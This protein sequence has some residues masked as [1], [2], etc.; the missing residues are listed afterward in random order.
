MKQKTNFNSNLKS[1]KE[2]SKKVVRP[3]SVFKKEVGPIK[4]L[5]KNQEKINDNNSIENKKENDE[6][7]D[8]NLL[9]ESKL[10]KN[11]TESNFNNFNSLNSNDEIIPEN[12]IDNQLPLL[13]IN[14]HTLPNNRAKTAKDRYKLKL[15][16]LETMFNIKP[17][18]YY[19]N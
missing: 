16:T 19:E 18:F 11:Y 3:N 15:E 5:N 9:K 6:N 14:S 7:V 1:L 12:K 10:D 17:T 4:I 13:S 8:I 2:S